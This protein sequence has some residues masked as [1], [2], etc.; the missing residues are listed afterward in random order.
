MSLRARIAAV[1]SVAVAVAVLVA[2]I[3]V[4]IAVRSDLRGEL[5]RTLSQRAA[6]FTQPPPGAGGGHGT[7]FTPPQRG[8][9]DARSAGR[10]RF[11]SGF[12]S[13]VQPLPLGAPSGYVQF[14]S[15]TGSIHVPAGQGTS[16][17]IT[18]TPMDR[19]IARSGSGRGFADRQIGGTS[20]RVL[21]VGTGPMGAV[22]V[23]RPLSELQRELHRVLLILALVGVCGIAIAAAL[24]ALVARAALAPI[25]RFT[26][27][28]E[29]LVPVGS[30][31]RDGHW[32]AAT[33]E[34]SRRLPEQGRDELARLARSFNAT[35]AALELSVAAQRNLVADA[36]HELRTPIASLRANIQVLAEADRLP[37]SDQEALRADIVG[38]LDE[39]TRLVGDVVELARGN[40]GNAPRTE[41][42]LD[43]LVAAAVA[44]ARRRGSVPFELDLEPTTIVAD[45]AGVDRAIANLLENARKWSG[46]ARGAQPDREGDGTP[47]VE[48]SLR[49]GVLSVRDHGPGFREQ[50]LP[51][52][53]ERFYR[54]DTARSKPGS[55]LG[56]AI[57]R[58]TAEAHGGWVTAENAPGGGALLR[59]SFGATLAPAAA[60]ESTATRD[61]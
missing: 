23:A 58:Q 30:P 29:T 24:G 39:L 34:T 37:I 8:D 49:G 18:L 56:L 41:A 60:V 55:G 16:S 36:S 61:R 15:P 28:T 6:A 40:D 9:G 14:V 53:F 12:P 10:D 26:R 45:A 22:M 19:S 52:V 21:T 42:G 47:T 27:R 48:V 11:P 43:E 57:V 51:H 32:Q 46:D 25:E 38:E 5:D 54:A 50:D 2:A 35:L 31:Y 3:A 20:V 33:L 4:Y 17:A 44:R 59:V 1:S 13:Q 7:A